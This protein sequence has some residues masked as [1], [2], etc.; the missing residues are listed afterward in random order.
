MNFKCMKTTK[1]FLSVLKI[2]EL[3]KDLITGCIGP[4][5]DHMLMISSGQGWLS[6]LFQTS[7]KACCQVDQS[8]HDA[9]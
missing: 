1:D 5:N 6:Y 9:R 3:A 8:K 4:Q 2:E 7:T